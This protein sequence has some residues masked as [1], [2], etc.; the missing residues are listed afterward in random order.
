MQWLFFPFNQSKTLRF[1]M[2]THL[3][4]GLVPGC[5]S[6]LSYHDLLLSKSGTDRKT[7]RGQE[8]HKT[9]R[10]N[11]FGSGGP[12]ETNIENKDHA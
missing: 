1:P 4:M 9:N 10:G 11:K 12:V 8:L 2:G 6:H 7:W 3:I 5:P